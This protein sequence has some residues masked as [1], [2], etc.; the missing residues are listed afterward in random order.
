MSIDT[1][2]L[3]SHI[4]AARV[5]VGVLDLAICH[6]TTTDLDT[7][8]LEAHLIG[9]ERLHAITRGSETSPVRAQQ[10][11]VLTEDDASL[12]WS[13]N[14]YAEQFAN[15]TGAVTEDIEDGGLTGTAFFAHVRRH[16]RPLL[17]CPKGPKGP[18]PKYL[19]QRPVCDPTPLWTW[20]LVKRRGDD[21][22]ALQAVVDALTPGVVA[23][24][25][26]RGALWLPLNDPHRHSQ[27]D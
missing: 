5:S 15:S 12:W 2:M 1:W 13:W 4:Q 3:P 16:S 6:L 20:S 11:T 7:L 23:P 19:A 24:D 9:I 27:P 26:N 22:P 21:R 10:V 18:L 25:L 8:G 14:N 17:N